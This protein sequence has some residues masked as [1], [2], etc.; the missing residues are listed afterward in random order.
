MARKRPTKVAT[1]RSPARRQDNRQLDA[2]GDPETAWPIDSIFSAAV[3][4]NPAD[5]SMLGFGTWILF[6]TGRGQ[7]AEILVIT[8]E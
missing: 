5:T 4:T 8:M 6:A 7:P 3:P 1:I 2:V